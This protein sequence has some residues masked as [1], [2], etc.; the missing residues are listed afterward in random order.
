LRRRVTLPLSSGYVRK[1][2]ASSAA[3]VERMVWLA[4][5][6]FRRTIIAAP[7]VVEGSM[8]MVD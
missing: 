1:N 6:A 7:Y 2:A 3:W 5:E 8:T 4:P